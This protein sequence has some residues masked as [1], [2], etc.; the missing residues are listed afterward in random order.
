MENKKG[1]VKSD[2]NDLLIQGV[3]ENNIKLVKKALLNGADVNIY[4]DLPLRLALMY[5]NY[6]LTKLLLEYGANPHVGNDI[7]YT[8]YEPPFQEK[9]N[10]ENDRIYR[11]LLKYR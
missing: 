6:E 7:L 8:L 10:P 2:P 9:V 3:R 4:N 11:L 1:R 5:N